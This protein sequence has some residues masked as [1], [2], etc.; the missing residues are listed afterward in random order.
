MEHKLEPTLV[1]VGP[2]GTA[3]GR[4]PRRL[5]QALLLV[6]VAVAGFYAWRTVTLID[7]PDVGDPFDV[8]EALKRIEI[9]DA[10]N[11]F[12]FYAAA[13]A[14]LTRLRPIDRPLDWEETDWSKSSQGR[15]DYAISNKEA[16][17]LW[18]LG[19]ELPKANYHQPGE[20]TMETLLDVSHG[21]REFG[22]LAALEGSRLEAEGDNASAWA[23]Y[24]AILR[25]S[26]HS[27][28]GFMMERLVGA[29]IHKTANERL[30][31][32]AMDG[33]VDASL[34]REALREA[35]KFDAMGPPLSSTLK[36]EYLILMR[37]LVEMNTIVDYLPTP[38]APRD[39]YRQRPLLEKG[40]GHVQRL[41]VA[42]T[43]DQERSRRVFKLLYAN[44]LAQV[45]RPPRE[46]AHIAV[47]QPVV[48]YAKDPNAPAAA[49]AVAPEKLA[50]A[51]S[52][53]LL[54]NEAIELIG[55][56]PLWEGDGPLMKER[57]RQAALIITLATELYRREHGGMAP[58]INRDLIGPDLEVLPEGFNPDDRT[59][60]RPIG[61]SG[62]SPPA[63]R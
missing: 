45:D 27:V 63:N 41:H 29:A 24:R 32:W 28:Q 44:W 13:H 4:Y 50:R 38:G 23:W 51:I 57:K 18:R 58:T 15:R 56:R 34:L 19:S 2:A 54:A 21:L 16:L 22:R 48:I 25:S 12:T 14:K 6:A 7:L 35:Q 20:S 52:K 26:R 3:H 36:L 49:R 40:V 46:R 59:E 55:N 53:T 42:L 33:R 11:A 43:N 37:D 31:R 5:R 30:V 8:N 61:G 60:D 1:V 17:D 9:P 62:S 10:E 47:D 39:W